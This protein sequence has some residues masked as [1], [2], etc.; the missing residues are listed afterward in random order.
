MS[1][2][3]L[4]EC[5]RATLIMMLREQHQHSEYRYTG[6]HCGATQEH[7]CTG[8]ASSDLVLVPLTH[9]TPL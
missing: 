2:F 4:S 9:H 1:T 8:T 6:V 7:L 3:L 5:P